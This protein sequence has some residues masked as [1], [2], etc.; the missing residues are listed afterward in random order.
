MFLSSG[1]LPEELLDGYLEF[2]VDFV[3]VAYFHPVNQ[4]C[5]DHMFCFDIRRIKALSPRKK[6]VNLR[7]GFSGVHFFFFHPGLGIDHG[8]LRCF[9]L[10]AVL[11]Q[12]LIDDG[13]VKL[14]LARQRLDSFFF[15]CG[16]LFLRDVEILFR[17]L[18]RHL[19][20]LFVS[21]PGERD[22]FISWNGTD[23]GEKLFHFPFDCFIQRRNLIGALPIAGVSRRQFSIAAVKLILV[24]SGYAIGPLSYVPLI[25]VAKSAAAM[26]AVNDPGQKASRK[27][28][29]TATKIS[30][31]PK[32]ESGCYFLFLNVG[33][34]NRQR[35]PLCIEVFLWGVEQ[36][37]RSNTA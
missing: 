25:I 21:D 3:A 29:G 5:D 23:A 6:F 17:L 4:P 14:T 12:H 30:G 37:H 20:R 35:Q 9:E 15:Q 36:A 11:Q 1:T 13:Q 24:H 28:N 33:C 8:A 22:E 19:V 10:G 34:L 16:H 18:V 7:L 32:A 31:G 26:R 27:A 2:D